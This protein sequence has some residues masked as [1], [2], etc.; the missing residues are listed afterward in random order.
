MG[1]FSHKDVVTSFENVAE[2]IERSCLFLQ[3][4]ASSMLVAKSTI[5]SQ[6]SHA[7]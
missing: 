2:A 5:G 3:K 1:S 7:D 4:L 6:S